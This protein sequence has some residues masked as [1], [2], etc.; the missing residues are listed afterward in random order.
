MPNNVMPSLAQKIN[1]M[2]A[3]KEQENEAKAKYKALESEVLA[4]LLQENLKEFTTEAAVTAKITSKTTFKYLNESEMISI[5]K[6]KGFNN[7]IKV[8]VDTT[9]MNNM[10]KKEDNKLSDSEKLLVESIKPLTE[11]NESLGVSV[12]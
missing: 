9:P 12:K 8:S 2:K 6:E 1:L 10:L 4:E 3:Y 7:L 5:L 11:R